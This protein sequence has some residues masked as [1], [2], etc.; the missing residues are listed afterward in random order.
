MVRWRRYHAR[1]KRL[2]V[3]NN[4]R[5]EDHL[6]L[7]QFPPKYVTTSTQEDVTTIGAS[8]CIS[9]K[10]VVVQIQSFTVPNV[11]KRNR[12]HPDLDLNSNQQFSKTLQYLPRVV[13]RLRR[14]AWVEG[15]SDHPDRNFAYKLI[16]Y[17][18]NGVP[19]FYDGPRLNQTF[20]N[21]KSCVELR[22]DV[23]KSMLY[24][25]NK[26]WKVGPFANQPFDY[27]V[28]SPM[29]A[30]SKPSNIGPPKIRVIHDLSWPPYRSVNHFIP[31]SLCSVKYV[32]IDSA[33]SIIKKL[34]PGCLMAKIDLENAYKQIGV[35]QKDWYLLGSTWPNKDGVTQ[36]Y[37]D[38]VLP[39]GGRSSATLFNSFADGL[40]HIMFKNGV[41]YMIHYLAICLLQDRQIR[42]SAL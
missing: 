23:E 25:I 30:F 27:F 17:I 41:S 28:G 1:I 20:P 11:I 31:E 29:G 2:K 36:F 5:T 13:T 3:V 38:T 15:L 6:T 34:G 14:A 9:V 7:G 22:E 19:L 16:E 40:E 21:W 26:Q 32:T 24:D 37:F 4:S 42:M 39:F 35:R 8:D 18:D 12:T 10:D 33:V